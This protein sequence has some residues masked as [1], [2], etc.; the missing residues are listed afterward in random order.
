GKRLGAEARGAPGTIAKGGNAIERFAARIGVTL[1]ANDS[2]GLSYR[3]RVSPRGMTKLLGYVEKTAPWYQTLR[4]G[5]ATGGQGTL[6]SRLHGVPIRAK[7]GSLSGVSALSGWIYLRQT[8]SWA[9]FSILSR[10]TAYYSAKYLED[11][12][13]RVITR[14]A[15]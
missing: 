5:L 6:A 4:H 8:K 10:G 12:I 2:S 11:A 3:N 7:T 13:V 1:T 14:L 9:E 15:R